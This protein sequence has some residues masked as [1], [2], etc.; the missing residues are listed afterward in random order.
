MGKI[1]LAIL[2][3]GL[4]LSGKS[5][6]GIGTTTPEVSAKLDI[7]STSKGFLPPRM[8]SAQRDAIADVAQGLVIFNTTTGGLEI[9]SAGWKKLAVAGANTDITSLGGLTEQRLVRSITGP[10]NVSSY[11]PGDIVYDQSSSDYY[12]FKF[13]A[14]QSSLGIDGNDEIGFNIGGYGGKV[15]LRFKPARSMIQSISVGV[16]NASNAVLSVFSALEPCESGFTSVKSSSLI[17]SS[18]SVSGTGLLTFTFPNPL[19]L[20]PNTF[21][22][23]TFDDL[24]SVQSIFVKY[25]TTDPMFTNSYGGCTIDVG[26]SPAVRLQYVNYVLY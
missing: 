13:I 16:R 18:A 21:Y 19:T 7:F 24:S 10:I 22:Y 11:S 4:A 9:Y 23:M 14:P 6:I 2:L 26:M 1:L 20:T 15:V 17:A 8:T 25:S 5:Q 3:S 12:F